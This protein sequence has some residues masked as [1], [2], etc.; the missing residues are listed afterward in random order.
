MESCWNTRARRPC[1]YACI[2]TPP[3]AAGRF[4]LPTTEEWGEGKGEGIPISHANS[5]EGAP[6]PSPL[7]AR[8]LQGEGA[9]GPST[10]V[11]VSRCADAG[12]ATAFCLVQT[13][14]HTLSSEHRQNGSKERMCY[15]YVE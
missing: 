3:H 13:L 11:V 15:E 9:G 14:R 2:L 5:M 4:P 1:H 6:L 7:P 12:M 10:M 8:A